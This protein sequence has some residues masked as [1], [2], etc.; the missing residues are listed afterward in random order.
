MSTLLQARTPIGTY[1]PQ[2]AASATRPLRSRVAASWRLAL[3]VSAVLVFCWAGKWLASRLGIEVLPGSGDAAELMIFSALVVYVFAMALPFVPGIEIGLALMLILGDNGI[4]LVYV[5]TQVALTLSFLLGRL[6]PAP[7]I[8]DALQWL[9]MTRAARLVAQ[10][11][12]VSPTERA[13]LLVGHSLTPWLR[14]LVKHRYVALAVV[15]NLP[16]NALIG[17]AGGIGVIAGMSRAFRFF[18]FLLLVG[19]A[20]TPVPIFLLLTR[21]GA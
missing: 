11:G 19:I 15:L 14:H 5:A 3:L 4:V 7:L 20:T 18:P 6:V 10:V 16:G 8:S 9:G 17:G 12:A 21:G 2:N 13:A 1:V